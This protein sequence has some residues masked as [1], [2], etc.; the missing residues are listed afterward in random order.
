VG[1]FVGVVGSFVG[2]GV[3]K[4]TPEDI[5]FAIHNTGNAV[6]HV[7]VPEFIHAVVVAV[8]SPTLPE[9]PEELEAQFVQIV[10]SIPPEVVAPL[11]HVDVHVPAAEREFVNV[12]A[13]R[14]SQLDAIWTDGAD[15]GEFVGTPP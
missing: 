3:G 7:E 14:L 2:A 5:I 13:M 12:P 15:K 8:Q 4:F 6:L 1:A 10:V 9:T 11:H